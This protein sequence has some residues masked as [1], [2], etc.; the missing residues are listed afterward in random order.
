MPSDSQPQHTERLSTDDIKG[1][2]SPDSETLKDFGTAL[3]VI[4]TSDPEKGAVSDDAGPPD[5]G[6]AAWLVI[7]GC[8]CGS[9]STFGFAN[10]F[11]IFQSY[12][13]GVIPGATQSTIAWIGSLQYCLIF[14]P[15]F[16]A[17]YLADRGLF[18]IPLLC[19]SIVL[20]SPYGS[21]HL[22]NGTTDERHPSHNKVASTFIVAECA[23][24]WQLILCQGFAIG[25]SA[26][27]IFI[28]SLSIV[29]QWFDK[30]RG[31][32]FGI[33]ALGSSTGG[34]ILP[35]IL[36][37]LME[38]VGFKWTIRILSFV[39]LVL[40]TIFNLTIRPRVKITKA[41]R[42]PVSLKELLTH[43]ALMVCGDP[44]GA[45]IHANRQW[46]FQKIYVFGTAIVWLGLYNC[47]AF[48]DVSAQHI[49]VSPSKSLYT[50]VAAN[51][52]S[53][54]GRISSGFLAELFGTFNVFIAFS[55]IAAIMSFAWPFAHSYASLMVVA[56]LYGMASGAFISVLPAGT[57]RLVPKHML[58]RAMGVNG[59]F[60]AVGALVGNP[61]AGQILVSTGGFNAVGAWAGSTVLLAV[62]F[63]T[64]TRRVALGRWIGKF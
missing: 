38:S 7:L 14:L 44:N 63:L 56:I 12:Y 53:G 32:A 59:M 10:A 15:G 21:L 25:G 19:A 2:T 40:M 30:R 18:K 46:L 26:G 35:I 57:S 47:L 51:A 37:H 50:L 45:N 33:V 61:I 27:F 64:A 31:R 29:P 60:M 4:S 62:C 6:L 22:S 9:F 16:A 42:I 36:T 39:I 23:T 48:L 28:P 49:G 41:N 1:N 52:A 58:G 55:F 11:G 43:K 13:E 24:L 3:T 8:F 5:G 20:V 34:T 17:G 54:V